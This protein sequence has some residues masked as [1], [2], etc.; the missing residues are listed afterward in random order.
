VIVT[1]NKKRYAISD[2]AC[3]AIDCL[4]TMIE[5]DTTVPATKIVPCKNIDWSA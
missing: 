4:C 3:I 2:E 5:V 1:Y